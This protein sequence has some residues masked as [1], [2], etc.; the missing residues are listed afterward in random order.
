MVRIHSSIARIAVKYREG[1]DIAGARVEDAWSSETRGRTGDL[2]PPIDRRLG[3][4]SAGDSCRHLLS[5]F[6]VHGL[7]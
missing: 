6:G 2:L 5:R 4:G 1:A 3:S 7:C